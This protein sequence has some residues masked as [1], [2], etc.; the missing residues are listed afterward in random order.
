[1][2][3]AVKNGSDW[4]SIQRFFEATRAEKRENFVRLAFHG[5]L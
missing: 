1:M 2:G 5:V 4:V 3:V